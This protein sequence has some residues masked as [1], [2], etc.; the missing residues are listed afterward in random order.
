MRESK[1]LTAPVAAAVNKVLSFFAHDQF[2]TNTP[3]MD[4]LGD[5][6]KD[7]PEEDIS[8]LNVAVV[9][10]LNHDV[11]KDEDRTKLGCNILDETFFDTPDGGRWSIVNKFNPHYRPGGGSSE[12]PEITD[13]NNFANHLSAE[14][15][16]LSVFG[17]L[18]HALVSTPDELIDV[19][20]EDVSEVDY[21]DVEYYE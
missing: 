12:R 13:L 20:F 5:I 14:G 11:F 9:L 17:Y 19:D 21:L 7:L 1:V 4:E 3:T 15:V 10:L 8:A 16:N 2:G 6:V 18:V